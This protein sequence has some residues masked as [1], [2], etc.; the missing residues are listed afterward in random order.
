MPSI[1]ALGAWPRPGRGRTDGVGIYDRDYYRQGRSGFELRAPRTAIG[2]IILINICV[3]VLEEISPR[4]E[5]RPQTPVVADFLSD[6]VVP[7]SLEQKEGWREFTKWWEQDTLRHPWLWWQWLTC[8]FVHDPHDVQHILFN[9]LGLFF[10]GRSVEARYGTREFIRLYL[11]AV[12]FSSIIWAIATRLVDPQQLA[13]SYG[14]SGAIA[15]VVTLFVLNFPNQMLLFWMVI[16][17]PAW[18][19]GVIVIGYDVWGAIHRGDNVAYTAHLGGAA[20]ALL[21]YQLHWNLGR[22]FQWA[23]RLKFRPRPPL[24][25]FKPLDESDLAVDEADVDRILEKIHREGEKSLT[26]RERTIMENAS[27]RA[28]ERRR[29]ME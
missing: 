10:L 26:R 23:G 13:V 5:H 18:L 17:M 7:L 2:A 19:V 12:V 15:A 16:P 1:A 22:L 9:M 11:A 14:A 8:G 20:F 25:V 29:G 24:K 4:M 21:Y 28:Q 27:R 6:H 3:F